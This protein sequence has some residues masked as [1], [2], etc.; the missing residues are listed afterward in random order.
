MAWASDDEGVARIIRYVHAA[1]LAGRA[2]LA[3]E[4]LIILITAQ[5]NV[6]RGY[7]GMTIPKRE[8]DDVLDGA[9]VNLVEA[10][11][12]NPPKA[13]NIAHLRAWMKQVVYFHCAGVYRDKRE[14]WRRS[15]E[16]TDASYDDGTPESGRK[17]GREDYG[18]ESVE[19][20]EIVERHLDGL[21]EEHRIVIGYSVFAGMSSKEVCEI[22]ER[23]HGYDFKPNNI[24]QIAGRF[25]RKCQGDLEEQ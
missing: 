7:V 1:R 17:W 23:Q 10:V 12:D 16:S 25:R 3:A 21:S 8:V 20:M 5:E 9:L 4:A 6:V 11:H 2:D 18:F 15:L 19:Y 22:L 13:T 24:D 14:Q